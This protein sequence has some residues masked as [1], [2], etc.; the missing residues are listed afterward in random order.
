MPYTVV[1]DRDGKV[2]FSL[3]GAV[4]EADLAPLLARL[5]Q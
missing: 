1:L 2:A 4:K 5:T 3:Y